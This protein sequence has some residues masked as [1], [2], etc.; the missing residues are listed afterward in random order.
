MTS[1]A[2]SQRPTRVSSRRLRAEPRRAPLRASAARALDDA[3]ARATTVLEPSP[4]PEVRARRPA[5]GAPR[6]EPTRGEPARAE[7][8]R[9]ERMWAEPTRAPR[10]P[11]APLTARGPLD[12]STPTPGA[13]TREGRV[14]YVPR[15]LELPLRDVPRP[16]VKWVGGKTQLLAELFRLLP[17]RFGDY[18]E[19]FMGGGAVFFGLS[20]HGALDG[21][22][23]SLSDVN[24]ELVATYQAIRDDVSSVIRALS[25]H[26]YDK[27][28]YYAVRGEDPWRL[29]A[30]ARAA[31]LVFL[32][33]SGFNGL[34]RVNRRGEFNVPFGRYDNPRI[35]D[36]ENLLAVSRALSAATVEHRDFETVIDRAEK[37]DLVYFD[38]PYVPVSA[39]ASFVGYAQGGFDMEAQE[40]LG[41]VVDTLARRGVSVLLS[42]SDV[43]WMHTRY[44]QYRVERV[45]ARRNVNSR[46]SSRGP[47]GEVVVVHHAR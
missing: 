18:H 13:P 25:A 16:F 38:P 31:R 41:D 3:E 17:E 42:N 37:G 10:A 4:A 27:D 6:P 24:R 2:E 28:H 14:G 11:V 21:R 23:V 15:T 46:A 5:R 1:T 12:P 39:T 26:A 33:R 35:V 45:L 47:V 34:Y 22:R 20:R 29:G 19:P 9:D 8:T 43:P 44:K 40:R 36:E 30:A 7:P 32:N